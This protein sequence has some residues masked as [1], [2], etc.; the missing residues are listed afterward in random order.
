MRFSIHKKRY[1]LF[2]PMVAAGSLAVLL[3]AGGMSGTFRATR[4]APDNITADGTD[5]TDQTDSDKPAAVISFDG[6][7]L[8]KT[9]D[10][11]EDY[12]GRMIF[13]GESTTAHLRSRG[14]LREGRKTAQVWANDDN[15]MMLDLNILQKKIRYPRTGEEM[16]I[17]Q[18]A[19]REKPDYLV[20]S[21]GLNGVTAFGKNP[22]LYRRCYEKLIRG[23][24]EASPGTRVILQTVYPVADNQ[25]KFPDTD[26][27]NATIR[28]LNALLPEIARSADA[29]IVDTASV[30]RDGEGKLNAA[31]QTDGIHLTAEAYRAVLQYIREH[32]WK[33]FSQL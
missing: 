25:T 16:T 28:K 3:T 8:G 22:A 23:I 6:R 7:L 30:L 32:G 14:V 33:E 9:D 11:G 4:Q 31:Y 18:A 27:V 20:L 5:E 29:R 13:V 24:H 21:F 10:M 1:Y 12:I 15:T 2:L 19:A 17:T 26:E